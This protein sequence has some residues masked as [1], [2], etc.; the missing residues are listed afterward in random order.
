[1]D[2]A[3]LELLSGQECFR[4]L[5]KVPV[6][7][8]VYTDRALPAVQP[9]TFALREQAVIIRTSAHSRLALATPGKVVAFEADEFKD[10]GVRCGWSVVAIGHA[11]KVTDPVEL[12]AVRQLGLRAWAPDAED[13]Y[14]RISVEIVS[15]RRLP[16]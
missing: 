11:V 12:E 8:V 1:M 10:N 3:G 6:G 14:L 5:A 2:S 4:L 15:G 16:S 9:V 13:C 7:R